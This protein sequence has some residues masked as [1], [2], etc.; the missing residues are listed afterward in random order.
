MFIDTPASFATECGCSNDSFRAS[1]AEIRIRRDYI[2]SIFNVS[3]CN[4]RS[5]INKYCTI[6]CVG[7]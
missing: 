4:L 6:E 2:I 1:G 7:R 5:V 3:V